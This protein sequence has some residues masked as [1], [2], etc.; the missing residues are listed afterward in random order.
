MATSMIT[1]GG[2]GSYPTLGLEP[3][4]PIK[5][6]LVLNT[7]DRNA[8]PHRS[9]L[10]RDVA[11][12]YSK[13]FFKFKI[14]LA[15]G[16]GKEFEFMLE[17]PENPGCTQDFRINDKIVLSVTLQYPKNHR[18]SVTMLKEVKHDIE[19]ILERRHRFPDMEKRS[20]QH[21]SPIHRSPSPPILPAK[22]EA[23]RKGN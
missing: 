14:I 10:E 19:Q 13:C 4:E 16:F 20:I 22:G 15:Y 1:A 5:N 7:G 11:Q 6:H 8:L 9:S 3:R 21:R 17:P 2:E 12:I 23:H 18:Q